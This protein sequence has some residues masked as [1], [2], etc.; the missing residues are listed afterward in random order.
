MSA[1][2][3]ALRGAGGQIA[4]RVKR[5]YNYASSLTK[6]FYSTNDG[7]VPIIRV[8]TAIDAHEEELWCC[9]TRKT[10]MELNGRAL[11]NILLEAFSFPVR[12]WM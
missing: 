12:V 10:N 8:V 11:K 4:L 6:L 7:A 5:G 9:S 3:Q 1:L 2:G